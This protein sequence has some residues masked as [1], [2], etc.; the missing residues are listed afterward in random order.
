MCHLQTHPNSTWGSTV[1]GKGGPSPVNKKISQKEFLPGELS[2]YSAEKK[3][4][5]DICLD[6][7]DGGGRP[8]IVPPNKLVARHK[9]LVHLRPETSRSSLCCAKTGNLFLK[10]PPNPLQSGV[11][12]RTSFIKFFILGRNIQSKSYLKEWVL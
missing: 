3:I 4:F 10:V 6:L 7:V 8:A 12:K 1:E 9:L 5:P 2:G 11:I